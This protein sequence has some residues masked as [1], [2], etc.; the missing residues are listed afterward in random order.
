MPED[1]KSDV[2]ETGI[3]QIEAN[4]L[5]DEIVRATDVLYVTRIQKER[6][7][8]PEEY[9]AVKGSYVVTPE[10]LSCAK[11]K[12]AVLVSNHSCLYNMQL[13]MLTICRVAAPVAAGGRAE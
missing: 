10:T 7:A 8:T 5:T 1:V 4:N 2:A 9:E 12:M 6:F 11:K 13:L 3:S